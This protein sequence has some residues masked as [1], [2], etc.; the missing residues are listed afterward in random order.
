MQDTKIILPDSPEA[1]HQQ[2]VTLWVSRHGHA[3][4][5]E[6]IARFDGSTHSKCECGNICDKNYTKCKDCISKQDREKYKAMPFKEWDGETPLCLFNSDTYFWGE[7]DI[8]N[9]C[10]ENECNA[11]SLELVICN[12]NLPRE[13]D[14]E[15]FCDELP[16]DGDGDLPKELQKAIDDFNAAVKAYGKPLSWIEGKYRTSCAKSAPEKTSEA[17]FTDSQQPQAKIRS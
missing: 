9:Y 2:T 4:N 7:D 1:A 11:D 10:E 14:S 3:Y 17:R 8:E 5:D 13:L 16:D 6:R 15:F 12:P